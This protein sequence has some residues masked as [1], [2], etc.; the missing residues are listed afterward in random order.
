MYGKSV[1][2]KRAREKEKTDSKG[3]NGKKNGTGAGVW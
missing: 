2:L 3:S 1:Y